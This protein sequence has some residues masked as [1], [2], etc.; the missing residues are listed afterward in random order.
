MHSF[1]R[2]RFVRFVRLNVQEQT[3]ATK[4]FQE[5]AQ[6]SVSAHVHLPP[7]QLDSDISSLTVCSPSQEISERN[8]LGDFEPSLT[9]F[10]DSCYTVKER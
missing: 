9:V 7:C 3:L 4:L 8:S 1:T 5:I 10:V 2:P 6:A